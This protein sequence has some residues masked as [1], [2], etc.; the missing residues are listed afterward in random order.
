MPSP[1]SEPGPA[2]TLLPPVAESGQKKTTLHQFG[3]VGNRLVVE[4]KFYGVAAHSKV[5]V[6]A[7]VQKAVGSCGIPQGFS[8]LNGIAAWHCF[9]F[10]LLFVQSHEYMHMWRG[11]LVPLHPFHQAVQNN[12]C[13]MTVRPWQ[14]LWEAFVKLCSMLVC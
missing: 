8:C 2:N 7:Y 6:T 9:V 13:C 4:I 14:K 11:W 10:A 1:A 12:M 5:F 3:M